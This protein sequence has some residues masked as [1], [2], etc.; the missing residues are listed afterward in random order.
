MNF[1]FN[2][3]GSSLLWRPHGDLIPARGFWFSG[4]FRRVLPS[5][6]S[7]LRLCRAFLVSGVFGAAC[8]SIFTVAAFE[9]SLDHSGVSSRFWHLLTVFFHFR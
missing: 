6:T 7:S 9:S 8:G 3:A 2:S 1:K 5:S 4:S